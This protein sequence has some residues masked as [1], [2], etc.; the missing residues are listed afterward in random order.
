[1]RSLFNRILIMYNSH[2]T[3]K[4]QKR[5]IYGKSYF[6]QPSQIFQIKMEIDFHS[7]QGY[8]HAY[9]PLKKQKQVQMRFHQLVWDVAGGLKC[10]LSPSHRLLGSPQVIL[11]RVWCHNTQQG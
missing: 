11:M 3:D 7:K 1:M 2:K 6:N 4:Y 10:R 9:K 8:H 5:E